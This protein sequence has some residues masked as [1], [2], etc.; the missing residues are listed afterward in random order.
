M[1]K[2]SILDT[3]RNMAQQSKKPS[4]ILRYLAIDL[5]MTDQIE[6]MKLFSE[7]LNVTLGEVTAIGGWWYEGEREL[8]DND[9]N[10]YLKSVVEDYQLDG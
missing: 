8:N 3:I 2:Q 10:A 5:E 4:D 7:A 1:D 6:M 9:I